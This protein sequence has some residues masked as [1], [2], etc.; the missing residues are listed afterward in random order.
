MRR[1]IRPRGLSRRFVL[2]VATV[3]AVGG[4]VRLG[5]R[6][7]AGQVPRPPT[8][9]PGWVFVGDRREVRFP[10]GSRVVLGDQSGHSPENRIVW[11]RHQPVPADAPRPAPPCAP[12]FR[13]T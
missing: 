5:R 8:N 6:R 11:V 7:S 2:L 10:D 9:D 4:L 12:P 1:R 3:V 13:P